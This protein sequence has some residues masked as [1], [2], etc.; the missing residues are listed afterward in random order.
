M[1]RPPKGWPTLLSP[2]FLV[3]RHQPHVFVRIL[4]ASLCRLGASLCMLSGW[5]VAWCMG[6]PPGGDRQSGRPLK[7]LGCSGVSES[8]RR[9]TDGCCPRGGRCR[10]APLC[11]RDRDLRALPAVPLR[12]AT[13]RAPNVEALGVSRGPGPPVRHRSPTSSAMVE[14]LARHQRFPRHRRLGGSSGC[15]QPSSHRTHT[16]RRDDSRNLP[17]LPDA[18]RDSSCGGVRLASSVA[19]GSSPAA[20]QGVCLETCRQ[21][22]VCRLESVVSAMLGSASVLVGIWWRVATSASQGGPL[23]RCALRFVLAPEV[24]SRTT[25]AGLARPS[26][27]PVSVAC[28]SQVGFDAAPCLVPD[29]CEGVM[30][31]LVKCGVVS[32]SKPCWHE[33]TSM[34]SE[35]QVPHGFVCCS[36]AR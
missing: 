15:G 35:A 25:R 24:G 13:E 7:F 14:P 2:V 5:R 30:L 11:R 26:S 31:R 16:C 33:S 32:T 9:S 10:F 28:A 22:W 23:G 1:V 17:R 3:L 27:V 18:V 4:G 36:R 34:Y 6:C 29:Y 21:R 12:P 20:P 8:M 19:V